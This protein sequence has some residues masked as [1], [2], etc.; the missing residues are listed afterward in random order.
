MTIKEA[1]AKAKKEFDWTWAPYEPVTVAVGFINDEGREDETALDLWGDDAEKE[2]DYLWN[3]LHA[4]F[5]ADIDGV[6]YVETHFYGW[7]G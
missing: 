5:G 3:D 2:L 1:I 6:T 4:E 7:E